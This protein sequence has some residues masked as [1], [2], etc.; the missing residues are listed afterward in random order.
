ML[1]GYARC[2]T[3]DQDLTAQRDDLKAL[4]VTAKRIYVDTA[5]PGPTA[6]GPASA[7]PLPPVE[8]AT[9]SSSPSSTDSPDLYPTHATS[10]TNSPAA[11]SN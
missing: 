6:T 8:P 10:S 3:D 11:R 5:S 1:V 2:S 7:K 4:G 9:P